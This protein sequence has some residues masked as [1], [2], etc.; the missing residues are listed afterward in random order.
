MGRL[1]AGAKYRGE[2]EERLNCVLKEA[3]ESNG[4]I[5]LFIDAIHSI[6]GAATTQGLLDAGNLLKPV[7]AWGEL[8]CIG[9]TTMDKYQEYIEKDSGLKRRFEKIFINQPTIE[10][11]ISILRG[12]KERYEVHHGIKI[13]DNALVASV[14]LSS[15]YISGCCLPDTAI[16]LMDEAAAT[17][18][19]EI[20]SKPKELDKVERR[21]RQLEMEH[22]L[23][24]TENHVISRERHERLVEAKVSLEFEFA[25]LKKE[26]SRLDA[27]WQ[28]Q[29]ENIDQRR[30]LK[31]EID[32]V[33][34]EIQQAERDYDLTRVAM[35][36]YGKL[37]T[38]LEALE[39]M[40]ELSTQSETAGHSILH[41]EVN[42]T[43]IAKII[44]KRTSIPISKL[45]T[46]SP[47]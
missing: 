42:E 1:I 13:S 8:R 24:Q 19:M 18:K 30:T 39:Q 40:E 44:S 12:L 36:K 22:L 14:T 32:L 3:T 16:S 25:D 26:H 10:E 45:M 6:M 20:T 43:D 41:E 46:E 4:K 2:F 47:V 7:L 9:A 31:K 28:S 5:I 29:K 34:A 21:I 27:Q 33:K 17:L 11:T 15:Q 38:L 37:Q 23:L 35:L